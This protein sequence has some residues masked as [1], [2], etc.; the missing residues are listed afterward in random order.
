M[1]VDATELPQPERIDIQLR[2]RNAVKKLIIGRDRIFIFIS[3]D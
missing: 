3:L 2:H 1:G